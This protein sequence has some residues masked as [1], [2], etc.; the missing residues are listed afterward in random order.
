MRNGPLPGNA[1]GYTDT[2]YFGV[3]LFFDGSQF[4]NIPGLSVYA[5]M[6]ADGPGNG[7]PVFS[8]NAADTTMGWPYNSVPGTGSRIY[9]DPDKKLKV[10]MNQF[11]TYRQDVFNHDLITAPTAGHPLNGR[12]GTADMIGQFTLKVEQNVFCKDL[13]VYFDADI[14]EDCSVDLADMAYLVSD[15]LKCNDPLNLDCL[16]VP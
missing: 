7:N 15:W 5:Q 13:G 9:S 8:A 14:N 3:N 12:D 11:V 6:D 16:D 1:R 4:D 10:T 2:G